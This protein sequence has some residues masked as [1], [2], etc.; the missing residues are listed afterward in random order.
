MVL[1]SY[2]KINLSLKVGYKNNNGLHAIQSY[3]CLINL[4]DKIKL[5]KIKSKKDKI[6]FKG[7]FAKLVKIKKNTIINL[8]KFLRSL[9]LISNTYSVIITKNIPVFGGLGGGTGNAVS[10]LKYFLNDRLN[11]S[12]LNKVEKIIG[13]D[14]KLFFYKQGF[15]QNL[16]SIIKI[17]N[18]KEFFFVLVQP[19]I[20]CSTRKIY[21]ELRHHSPKEI[22]NK[23]K[24]RKKNKFI[25]FLKKKNNDLQ[26]VVEKKYP[27]LSK[28]LLDIQSEKGCCFSRMTG[29][30]SVCY[31][32]FKNQKNAKKA[33]YKLKMKY[34]K[35]W[36]SFAK[37]V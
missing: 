13:S 35:L 22:F 25:K 8:L 30:G 15:V 12:I 2:A 37:T 21:S 16:S 6:I 33:L 23:E 5:K 17:Q 4:T 10:I 27:P 28:L 24:I 36:L 31:G 14:L 9:K 3:F 7:P 26:S 1:N 20:K 32:L 34:P 19:K 18:K 11:K 29:S